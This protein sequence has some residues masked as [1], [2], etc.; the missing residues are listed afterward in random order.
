MISMKTDRQSDEL[1]SS[2]QRRLMVARSRPSEHWIILAENVPD[3]PDGARPREPVVDRHAAYSYADSQGLPLL[4]EAVALR[5]TKVSR[6]LMVD[7]ANVI[8]TG[9]ALHAV[10]LVFRDCYGRGYRRALYPIPTYCGVHNMMVATG[11]D[12]RGIALSGAAVDADL[13]LLQ[14][15]CREP[16]VLYLNFPHNPTGIAPSAEYLDAILAFAEYHDVF[17][18][19]DAVY[20]AFRFSADTADTPVDRAMRDLNFIIVNSVSKNYGRPG[21]RIGWALGAAVTVSRLV[22]RLEWEA[23][24]INSRAQWAAA[25]LLGQDNTALVEAV[26]RGRETYR[27]NARGEL[28]VKLPPA[29]T[30]VWLDLGLE[31][32][33][34]FADFSL[35]NYG[36]VLATSSNY[37][38]ALPGYIRFPTGIR[39]DLIVEG[40]DL[41]QRAL[42]DWGSRVK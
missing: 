7:P 36:L 21:D 30:Q 14:E 39:P 2:L 4:R 18:V 28:A 3:W 11:L 25:A 38:P 34:G 42:A 27:E 41:L 40:L 10:G 20:D 37:V 15:V 35:Y 6:S 1:L 13:A 32:V 26:L 31:D 9:G 17:V 24:S 23:V 12:A 5:E 22:A 8:V 29:G 16:T 19:Y 33:E